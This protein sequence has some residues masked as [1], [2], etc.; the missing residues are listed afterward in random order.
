MRRKKLKRA[1]DSAIE[2]QQRSELLIVDQ[3][4]RQAEARKRIK[5][6]EAEVR[7]LKQALRK[8]A[9]RK[10]RTREGVLPPTA[11][12]GDKSAAPTPAGS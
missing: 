2:A 6:L 10:R 1:L 8:Q 4:Q 7:T 5:A 3:A 12:N 9:P 11:A